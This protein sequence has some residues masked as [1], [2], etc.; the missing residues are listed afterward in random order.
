[1]NDFWT[2]VFYKDG[3]LL[4]FVSSSFMADSEA[5]ARIIGAMI[6]LVVGVEFTGEALEVRH[7]Q[8]YVPAKLAQREVA[9]LSGP[10]FSRAVAEKTA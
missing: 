3:N 1:M 7:G 6:E 2:P 10:A 5:G 8:R 9:I 4:V